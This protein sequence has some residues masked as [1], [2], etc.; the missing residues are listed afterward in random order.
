LQPLTPSLNL[1]IGRNFLN[2]E[3]PP[4]LNGFSS[5]TI[6]R[7]DS[8]GTITLGNNVTFNSPVTLRSPNGSINTTG[9]TLTATGDITL[10]ANQ[11]ITTGN[12]TNSGH[13]IAITSKLGN[14]D[15]R[16]GKLNTSSTTGDG[17]AIA[18][19]A[20]A[21]NITTAN[22][23]T[24]GGM[25]GGDITLTTN[26]GAINTTTGILNALGGKTGGNIS[27]EAPGNIDTGNFADFLVSGFNGNSGNIS[28]ISRNGSINTSAGT[29][30]TGSAFGNGGDITLNA[31]AG[32][33]SVAGIDAS[34]KR[35][36]GGNLN[37]IAGGNLNL[38]G[39]I[40]TNNNNIAFNRPVTLGGNA[41]V[42]I[43][44]GTGDIIFNNTVDG[45]YN[46]AL[47]TNTGSVRFNN[48]V[49][50]GS[51][52]L[53]DLF[54]QGELTTT[55]PAGISITALNNITTG[56]IT[57]PGGITLSSSSGQIATRGILNS[58]SSADG[59]NINLNARG[60]ITVRQI[61]GQSLGMG[62]GG[63]VEI[64]TNSFVQASGSFPDQNGVN[65]S[66]SA[67]GGTEGGTIIIRHGGGGVTPFIVGNPA[68][69]GT[70]GA[71]TR[72]NRAPEQTISPTQEYLFT[73]T[74]DADR[75]QIISVSDPTKPQLPST[76]IPVS[77]PTKPPLLPTPIPVPEPI[78]SLDGSSPCRGNFRL[79]TIESQ[80]GKSPVV[81]YARSLP[82]QLE[83]VLVRPEGPPIGKVI[84]KANAA[85]LQQ[86]LAE[87]R[88]TV[89][90]PIRPKAFL[91]SA[92]QLYQWLITPLEPDLKAL[93]IDTLIFCM[94]AGLRTIPMAAL[95]DGRQFLVENYS[96]GSIN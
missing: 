50:G 51:V 14:I 75:L 77:D 10:A 45:T 4:R 85:A 42:N 93:G 1:D 28:I 82:N 63:N 56:N 3:A 72:G 67:A 37:L 22:L 57:S 8:S 41:S 16:A 18:L 80:S 34:S 49:V 64:T 86:T 13:A 23:D 43:L 36:T 89:S 68:T 47:S 88:Q 79:K 92:Q 61:N 40:K 31:S 38:S 21:G 87:F 59:G 30:F 54:I 12:I 52:P 81:I 62:T 53:N 90:N 19:T 71:I 35:N 2:A 11:N 95:H 32:N 29:L 73:H 44:R 83:L 78:Q 5:I 70:A 76:P 58:S 91:A 9:F 74:Q 17:G 15:T 20:A 24:S 7:E 46:L 96:I 94:D 48:N 69:N 6:G 27:I 25:K 33:I 26:S 39:D 65:A 66:V 60:S 84:P 55:N